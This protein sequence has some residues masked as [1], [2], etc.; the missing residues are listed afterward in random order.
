MPNVMTALPNVDGALYS[1]PETLA[2]AHECRAVTLPRR[3]TR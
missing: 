1:T 3:E 2:D